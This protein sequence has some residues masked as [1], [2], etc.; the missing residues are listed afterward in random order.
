MLMSESALLVRF[1]WLEADIPDEKNGG[2]TFQFSDEVP[3]FFE[4][5]GLTEKWISCPHILKTILNLV[6]SYDDVFGVDSTD[7]EEK[8]LVRL[9]P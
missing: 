6:I 2:S 4:F 3:R 1:G 9:E 7:Q 5:G 8:K